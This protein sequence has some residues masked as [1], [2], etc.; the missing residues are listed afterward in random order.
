MNENLTP[1][2]EQEKQAEQTRVMPP[3]DPSAQPVRRR[4]SDRYADEA[5]AEGQAAQPA[6]PETPV[7]EN[8]MTISRPV[9]RVVAPQDTTARPAVPRPNVLNRIEQSAAHPVTPEDGGTTT[10]RPMGTP[11]GF[12][13]R[14][15]MQMESRSQERGAPIPRSGSGTGPRLPS[16]VSGNHAQR[17]VG[18]G[19]SASSQKRKGGSK[20]LIAIVSALLLIGL[21]IV[22]IMMLGQKDADL[23][24]QARQAVSGILPGGEEGE[25]TVPATASGFSAAIDRG[26]A[27][28]DVVFNLTTSKSVTQVRL[29]DEAGTPLDNATGIAVTEN[30]DS[31][32]WMIN[33]PVNDGF[34][35]LVFA[36]IFDGTNWLNTERSQN[37]EI[38]MPGPTA[39]ID[40]AAFS[41][42]NETAGNNG[43]FEEAPVD[44][45]VEDP[46]AAPVEEAVEEPTA[47][48]TDRPS[49]TPTLAVTPT[50]TVVTAATPTLVPASMALTQAPIGIVPSEEPPAEEWPEAWPDDLGEDPQQEE[51]EEPET[52][53]TATPA[54]KGVAAASAD[55]SLIRDTVIYNGSSKVDSYLRE[56]P[57][58]MPVA[59]SYI[60]QPYGVMTYRGN[61]FRQNAAV[62]TVGDLSGMEL[63]WTAEAGSVK[64]S[65]SWYYGIGW[66]GQAAIIKWSKEVRAATN[67]NAD[68]KD[69][70]AL[71]EVI[72]AGMDG[73]IYFLDLADG[74]ETRKAINLGFPMRGT[75]SLHPLGYPIMTVGQYA[76]KMA[77][78]TGDIGLRFYNLL[79]QKQDYWIDGLDGKSNRPYYEVGAFD[80]S[81]LIDPNTDTLVAIGTN[82]M[83]YTASLN[84][85]YSVSEEKVTIKP[86]LVSMKSRTKGQ[87]NKYTA[88]QSSPAMYGSYVYYAD[89]QGI[90][91]CVDTTTM[92]TVWAVETGDAVEA[93]I[94][95]DMDENGDLWLYTANTLENR[96]RGDCSIRR[97]NALTGEESWTRALNLVKAKNNK[98]PGAMASPV[99]GQNELANLVYFTLSNVSANGMMTIFG[100]TATA[101][102]G[103]LVALDKTTGEV[104]W[105]H[106]LSAYSYSSPVAVYSEEGRGWI[107]QAASNGQITLLDGLTGDV[108]DTL[109]VEGTIDASPAVYNDIL[110]IGTTGKNTT[111]IYGIKLQ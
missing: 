3:V 54:L 107:V 92:T 85:V 20:L 21:V 49:P 7:F 6:E 111:F 75:P 62:G 50:P 28:L 55:P 37:L 90:L 84:T 91:R 43:P 44:I 100:E 71:K 65:S 15:P 17:P 67:I 25:S 38:A 94:A 22:A 82:G 30:A 80:T 52:P 70:T 109:K 46:V 32:I 10:R 99:I 40:V 81:A 13:P 98:T 63:L 108:V 89:M 74:Q 11:P 83:L 34:E 68:K 33:L 47:D 23:L 8:D 96:S 66:T 69:T 72:I 103:L 36:Q 48:P 86:T 59:D 18:T 106:Q 27:P 16:S 97:Y 60:T 5:P 4:R 29:V 76:R 101:A 93:A 77:S 64:G 79:T 42:I 73:K 105:A 24:D 57:L 41:E 26:T 9:T 35:G 61:A 95:L 45:D 88:V 102:D 1:N 110:V 31:I 2:P 87:A 78:G 53:P 104:A 58:N 14:Q 39:T 51:E 56:R 12:T 19:R